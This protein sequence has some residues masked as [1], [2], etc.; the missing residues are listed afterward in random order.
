MR[1]R[2]WKHDLLMAKN[3]FDNGFG[4]Y[5]SVIGRKG[6]KIPPSPWVVNAFLSLRVIWLINYIEVSAESCSFMIF[7]HFEHQWKFIW[8]ESNRPRRS[9]VDAKMLPLLWNKSDGIV[10]RLIEGAAIPLQRLLTPSSDTTGCGGFDFRI[11]FIHEM[12]H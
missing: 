3:C 5:G 10:Y 12:L 1:G 7:V 6:N 8:K 4:L 11:D 2:I 9:G